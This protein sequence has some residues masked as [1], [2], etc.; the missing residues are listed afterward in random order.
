VAE[1]LALFRLQFGLQF[2]RC[3]K[4]SCHT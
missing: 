4:L 1:S 2:Y 3:H